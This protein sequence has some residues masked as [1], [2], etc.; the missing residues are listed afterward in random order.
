MQNTFGKAT[1]KIDTDLID[2]FSNPLKPDN[3]E[4]E[5]EQIREAIRESKISPKKYSNPLDKFTVK[6]QP[7]GKS[8]LQKTSPSDGKQKTVNVKVDKK[9]VEE[10][11]EEEASEE[12]PSEEEV[13]EEPS[14]EE[15][16]EERQALVTLIDTETEKRDAIM[17]EYNQSSSK[18]GRFERQGKKDLAVEVGK[19][20]EEIMSRY[21]KQSSL[22]GRLQRKLTAYDNDKTAKVTV[23]PSGVGS[24]IAKSKEDLTTYYKS[25]K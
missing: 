24:Q 19:E 6:Q 25:I 15:V 12:E 4:K 18:R 21:N 7:G 13:D 8:F 17:T 11:S 5:L 3:E 2:L 20:M 14:E 9:L 23:K 10:P 22:V 16:D 1:Q